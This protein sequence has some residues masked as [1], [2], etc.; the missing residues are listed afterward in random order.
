M[1]KQDLPNSPTNKSRRAFLN[2]EPTIRE[3]L[4]KQG[5]IIQ[6]LIEDMDRLQEVLAQ[7]FSNYM[8][9]VG[10][11]LRQDIEHNCIKVSSCCGA[12][13]AGDLEETLLCGA[14]GEHCEPIDEHEA[15]DCQYKR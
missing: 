5:D 4:L 10:E 8:D 13:F 7:E 15:K 14:C 9:S 11:D 12:R 6:D 2:K 3:T 1:K